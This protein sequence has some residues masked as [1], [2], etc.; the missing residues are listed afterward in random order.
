MLTSPLEL[1]TLGQIVEEL[2]NGGDL[3][4]F[5]RH[6]SL[7]QNQ[8]GGGGVSAERVQRLGALPAIVGAPGRLA[9]DGDEFRP[10]RPRRRHPTL[11]AALEQDGIDPVEKN[12]QPAL[13][14]YAVGEGRKNPNGSC[15]RPRCRR[16]RR[17]SKS[18]RKPPEAAPRPTEKR[19]ARAPA[20]LESP[21]NASKAGLTDPAASPRG[22]S[23]AGG[24][25]HVSG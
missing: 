2:G 3:V 16:N 24:E 12:A 25:R 1:A 13:A 9:V 15:P 18:C 6:A 20:R 19:R 10:V 23:D 14:G 17:K 8:T 11:E 5:L 7:R 22:V 21:K 4:G